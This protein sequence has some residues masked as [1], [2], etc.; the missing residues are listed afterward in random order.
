MKQETYLE[1]YRIYSNEAGREVS[2]TGAAINYKAIDTRSNEPVLLQ[3][4]PVAL[5]E[6]DKLQQLRER[7]E[8]AKKLDHVNVA[9]T[10]AVGVEHDYFVVVSEFLEVKQR[11][12][13][14]P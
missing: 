10:R 7:A 11:T 13:G 8:T 12:R 2:R 3:L 4:L 6:P 1:H 5:I 9:K 14:S